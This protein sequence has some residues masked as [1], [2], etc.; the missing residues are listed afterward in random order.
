MT[1]ATADG[2]GA[3]AAPKLITQYLKDLSFENP[4]APHVH[5]IRGELPRAQLTLDVRA[6]TIAPMQY[7]VS[8]VL[9]ISAR[10]EPET[11]YLV[12]LEYAGLFDV[13][14]VPEEHV[15]PLLMI[16]GPRI[17]FPFAREIL[18]KA[19][20]DG[21]YPPVLVNPIDFLA[22]FREQMQ[23]REQQAAQPA[24]NAPPGNA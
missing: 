17:L 3:P 16:E 24:A 20:H 19:T 13:T 1:D 21:G 5:L 7:E 9:G 10:R 22:V 8:L 15:T 23:R 11:I 2:A 4:G 18:A 14:G 6:R 12:E